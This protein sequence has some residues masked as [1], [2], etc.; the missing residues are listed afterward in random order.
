[1]NMQPTLDSA[2]Y[3]NSAQR[4]NVQ[5]LREMLGFD[6]ASNDGLI[7]SLK[8]LDLSYRPISGVERDNSILD[9]LNQLSAS[10]EESG[11]HRLATWEKGWAENLARV[12]SEGITK[13]TLQP[14]YCRYKRY[15]LQ[16]N[17]VESQNPNFETDV[18]SVIRP[19]IFLN[20]LKPYSKIV[21]FG[22]GTGTSLMILSNLFPEKEIWGS[23]WTQ[24]SVELCN[25]LAKE[26]DRHFKAFRFDMFSPQ[27][28]ESVSLDQNTAVLTVHSMEQLS[29]GFGSFLKLLEESSTGL[30]LHIEPI[31]EYYDSNSLLDSLALR[32]HSKR[33]YLNGY[34]SSVAKL[35]SEGKA[36][37]IFE[38]RLFFG[39][40]F[41][42][43]YSLLAWQPIHK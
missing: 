33:K 34:R 10:S 19:L 36:R 43:G 41:H 32:Y 31:A 6:F 17:I 11:P 29:D 35:A 25:L 16:G 12:K 5:S 23:D 18:N 38:K 39:S 30:C 2:L 21:E 3:P 42:E 9:M 1:M 15:R 27:L 26:T 4:L 13:T 40:L 8:E 24:S 20:F 28:P 37:I 14:G 7:R 22:S